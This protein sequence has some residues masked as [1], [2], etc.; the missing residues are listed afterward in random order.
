[1]FIQQ[2][3]QDIKDK[4]VARQFLVLLKYLPSKLFR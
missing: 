4:S 3:D 1:M 2:S